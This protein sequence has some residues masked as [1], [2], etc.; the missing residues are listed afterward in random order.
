MAEC[1]LLY[2]CRKCGVVFEDG[3]CLGEGAAELLNNTYC[4]GADPNRNLQI[5][6]FMDRS[7]HYLCD[8]IGDYAGFRRAEAEKDAPHA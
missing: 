5:G 3:S 2:K 7:S 1:R 8:G 4:A 6:I